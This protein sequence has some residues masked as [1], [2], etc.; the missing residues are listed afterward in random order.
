MWD[1]SENH[2]GKVPKPKNEWIFHE[3]PK[4]VSDEL[5]DQVNAIINKQEEANK[6]T[7]QPLNQRTNLFTSFLK[8]HNGHTMKIQSKTRKYSC[9]KCKVR[10][11][12]DTL[13]YIFHN[14]LSEFT[15]SESEIAHYTN[16][17]QEIVKALKQEI[18][19]SKKKLEGTLTKM[20]RLIELNIAG[21]IPKEGFRKH[22]EPLHQQGEELQKHITLREKEFQKL[23]IERNSMGDIIQSSKEI[24]NSW[25]KLSHVEKRNII[26]TVTTSI[27]FDGELININLKQVSPKTAPHGQH[28]PT[29]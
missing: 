5:W 7:N 26:E 17:S 22:Y 6:H 29:I 1:Y 15:L 2:S 28:I 14:R 20:D 24:Y 13:E 21:E 4:I 12:K 27:E 11:D 10:I 19:L 3:C 18:Q 16:S 9:P 23:I 8:C 25:D